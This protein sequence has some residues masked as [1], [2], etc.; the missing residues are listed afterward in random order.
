MEDGSAEDC[1]VE[2]GS[3]ENGSAEYCS[4]K[5]GYLHWCCC[6]FILFGWFCLLEKTHIFVVKIN[7]IFTVSNW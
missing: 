5:D 1:S 3:G 4:V 7:C 2:D 6:E